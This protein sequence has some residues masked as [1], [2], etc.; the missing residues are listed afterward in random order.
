MSLMKKSSRNCELSGGREAAYITLS[1]SKV[2]ELRTEAGA[3]GIEWHHAAGH[4]K[5]RE[6]IAFFPKTRAEELKLNRLAELTDAYNLSMK[7]ERHALKSKGLPTS[8]AALWRHL[9]KA[10][11]QD[12]GYGCVPFKSGKYGP[13]VPSFGE[14]DGYYYF[15]SAEIA[16][17]AVKLLKI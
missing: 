17:A 7:K 13:F 6:V 5:G 15:E 10:G 3:H 14:P 2:L 12:E 16:A 9:E 8:K 1:G 4:S 11:A